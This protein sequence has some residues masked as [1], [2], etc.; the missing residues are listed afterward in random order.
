MIV[1][2]EKLDAEAAQKRLLRVQKILLEN[3]SLAER[4]YRLEELHA[5]M[6]IIKK[7]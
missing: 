4:R 1:D 3:L 7:P 6:R 5:L 2:T